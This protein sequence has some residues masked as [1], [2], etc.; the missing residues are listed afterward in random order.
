MMTGYGMLVAELLTDDAEA[1]GEVLDRMDVEE[2]AAAVDVL[3][4]LADLLDN[5]DDG[6]RYYPTLADTLRM[7]TTP[8]AAILRTMHG[9]DEAD[10]AD[11]DDDEG[12]G[13]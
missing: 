1:A 9:D 7:F 10:M 3:V 2:A 12:A 8:L 4:N 6:P 13:S 11:D 5:E